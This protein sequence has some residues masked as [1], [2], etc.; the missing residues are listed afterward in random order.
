MRTWRTATKR[1]IVAVALAGAAA[2]TL[3]T[4]AYAYNPVSVRAVTPD[5]IATGAM[6]D[7][8]ISGSGFDL[9][10]VV[11]AVSGSGVSVS[12]VSVHGGRTLTAEVAAAPGA[13]LG[14]R[15]LSVTIG[16]TYTASRSGAIRIDAAPT[17]AGVTPRHELRTSHPVR[18][19]LAGTGFR[20]G[21]RVTIDGTSLTDGLADV[22]SPTRATVLAA[23]DATS[24]LGVHAATLVNPDGGVVLDATAV[25]V[26]PTPHVTA[27]T[28]GVLD[29][30]E[31]TTATITGSGFLTG[32]TPTLG[33]GITVTVDA[34]TSTTLAVT[35]HVAA[36]ATVGRR[37][38][39]VKNPGAGEAAL[40]SRV[41]VEHQPIF[42]KWA[43]G[44]GATTWTTTLA[45][46]RFA[47]VPTVSFSGVGVTV[48]SSALNGS[49]H[50]VVSLTVTGAAPATWRTM[51]IHDATSSWVVRRGL[52]VRHAPTITS[53]PSLAQG[54]SYWTTTVKGANF[55]VCRRKEPTVSISGTGVTVN[56]VSTVYGFLMYVNVTVS[57]TAATGPRNVTMTNCDSGGTATSVGVF[58][59]TA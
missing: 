47:T 14:A 55:E 9:G 37:T 43:V 28:I 54:T 6:R 46:P 12:D 20:H 27:S 31:T 51:T 11:I 2:V 32:A 44:D 4:T 45:R 42:T 35:L 24:S 13:S 18:L 5:R 57:P 48:A 58:T 3:P 15:T 26:N 59:V 34:A 49:G 50:L 29:Q 33:P 19:E 41:A 25:T 16:G 1:S 10:G 8:T 39:T 53:F 56:M 17:L 21:M 7:V 52:K 30:D 38:L 40:G 36:T 23:F 22:S